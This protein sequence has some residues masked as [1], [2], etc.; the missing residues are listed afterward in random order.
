MD[1]LQV[2]RRVSSAG[3]SFEGLL[4]SVNKYVDTVKTHLTLMDALIARGEARRFGRISDVKVRDIR[5]HGSR[6]VAEVAGVQD[7]YMARISLNPRGHH[8]TCP[9]W[10]KNGPKVGPCKH[11]LALAQAWK[12]RTVLPAVESLSDRLM[13]ILEHT[14][15]DL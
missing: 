3:T 8:C 5:V 9:D 6:L 15:L 13:G 4:E 1:A 14:D 12:D 11:V 7:I 2:L 10:Q